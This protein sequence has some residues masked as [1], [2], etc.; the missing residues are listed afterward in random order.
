MAK[1]KVMD[2][3]KFKSIALPIEAY[4]IAKELA[5]KN[6]RSIARQI[7]FLIREATQ[8]SNSK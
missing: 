7:S 2:T 5:E 1:G 4:E 8:S 3:Q 6:E